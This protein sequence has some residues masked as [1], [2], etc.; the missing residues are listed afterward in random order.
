MTAGVWVHVG[1]CSGILH[2]HEYQGN[3]VRH[4]AVLVCTCSL[5]LW[6]NRDK[7]MHRGRSKPG[8]SNGP[9]RSLL[10]INKA[11]RDLWVTS[12]GQLWDPLPS[13]KCCRSKGHY[14]WNSY[15]GSSLPWVIPNTNTD[16]RCNGSRLDTCLTASC[17]Y[18]YDRAQ[19]IGWK[20][21]RSPPR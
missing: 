16:A 19:D 9:F 1:Q 6:C 15:S 21:I 20:A 12:D 4:V 2:M 10:Y 11:R 18:I 8:H 14:H 5:Y 3:I 7:L 13:L 17:R